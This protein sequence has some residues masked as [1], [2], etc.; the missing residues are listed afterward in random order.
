MPL[1]LALDVLELEDCEF[2][3]N[4]K[5]YLEN[6]F[7]P[8]VPGQVH[9]PEM[10]A[11]G[12]VPLDPV[13]ESSSFDHHETAQSHFKHSSRKPRL[14]SRGKKPGSLVERIKCSGQRWLS[15]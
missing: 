13:Q 14:L 5:F 11:R 6:I 7:S 12:V 1:I 4:Q 10:L 2:K 15:W 9:G 8:Q 3:A